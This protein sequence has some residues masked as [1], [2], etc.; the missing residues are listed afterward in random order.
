MLET[1]RDM[2]AGDS[3]AQVVANCMTVLQ[4]A[5]RAQSFSSRGVVIPLVNRIKARALLRSAC[6]QQRSCHALP[7]NAVL[8]TLA[9]PSVSVHVWA[10]PR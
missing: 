10:W 9:R 3:D 1:L 8:H 5:G 2:M 7:N 4:Q 6:G